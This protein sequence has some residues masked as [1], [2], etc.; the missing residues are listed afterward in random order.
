MPD[1][2]EPNK[3][4]QPYGQKRPVYRQKPFED[5]HNPEVSETTAGVGED[6][7]DIDASRDEPDAPRPPLTEAAK[8]AL[9]EAEDRRLAEKAVARERE[10]DGRGGLDPARYGDWEVKGITSDF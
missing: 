10:I 3:N 7:G 9:Q 1:S 5:A 6:G 2:G 4:P 8:R